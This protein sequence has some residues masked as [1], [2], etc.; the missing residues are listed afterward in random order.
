MSKNVI[1]AS[2]KFANAGNAEAN[3]DLRNPTNRLDDTRK[4]LKHAPKAREKLS[5][6]PRVP[7]MDR[8]ILARNLGRMVERAFGDGHKSKIPKLFDTA[9]GLGIGESHFKKRKRYI[10][11]TED[12]L[13]AKNTDSYVAHGKDY[14][15]LALALAQQIAVDLELSNDERE[16]L[17]IL[18]LVAGTSYESRTGIAEREESEQR[19]E[20]QRRLDQ[21]VERVATSVD[22]DWFRYWTQRNPIGVVGETGVMS[23][24]TLLE[25]AE[26]SWGRLLDIDEGISWKYENRIAPCLLLGYVDSRVEL[27]GGLQFYVSEKD[28]NSSGEKAALETGLLA[29]L[30]KFN[31]YPDEDIGSLP[32]FTDHPNWTGDPL[33]GLYVRKRLDLEIRFDPTT[34][35]WKSCIL[36]RYSRSENHDALFS[37]IPHRIKMGSSEWNIQ[38][39]IMNIGWSESGESIFAGRISDA[40]QHPGA[41][42]RIYK[43]IAFSCYPDDFMNQGVDNHDKCVLDF[44]DTDQAAFVIPSEKGFKFAFGNVQSRT[45]QLKYEI[46]TSE[47]KYS[48][49]PQE[50][51][52]GAILRNLAY[53]PEEN[54][55]DT[56]L[57]N[58]AND[59]FEKVT[60]LA[61]KV[62][63]DYES[64]IS[65]LDAG[66]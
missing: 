66:T 26:G 17:S 29:E 18:R 42:N 3:A 22:L 64:G 45:H 30:A 57:I 63:S 20:L 60:E 48:P 4:Q 53:A 41:E 35:R 12:A 65:R 31:L 7:K 2:N 21:V 36:L 40:P 1:D 10:Q 11:L 44:L 24:P 61:N 23:K 5:T 52:A 25:N 32:D 9:F 39:R 38:R 55:I 34:D 37:I 50:S 14:L 13:S 15:N 28:I 46:E 16:K 54:R 62:R 33:P 51:V 47:G 49:A 27:E 43:S 6:T 58:D 56:L 8:P 59:R 19:V